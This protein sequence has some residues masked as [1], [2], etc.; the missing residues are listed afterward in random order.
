MITIALQSIIAFAFAIS[1]IP[2]SSIS[3]ASGRVDIDT[4][5][6]V[7][8]RDDFHKSIEMLNAITEIDIDGS[9]FEIKPSL[10][11]RFYDFYLDT[12]SHTLLKSQKYFRFRKR[13]I[14]GFLNKQLLQLK[15]PTIVGNGQAALSEEKT[16]I[17]IRQNIENYNQI[18]EILLDQSNRSGSLS[19]TLSNSVSLQNISPLVSF[20]QNRDRFYLRDENGFTFFT[21]TFDELSVVNNLSV[22]HFYFIELELSEKLFERLSDNALE[23]N[24]SQLRSLQQT[25]F[26]KFNPMEISKLEVVVNELKLK[27]HT[28]NNSIAGVLLSLLLFIITVSI[29]LRKPFKNE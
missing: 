28:V 13:Y 25:L 7:E 4:R 23:A 1:L 18:T 24:L 15:Y 22:E 2:F 12:P 5:L 27:P 8:K 14:N 19:S 21:V 10:A 11:E 6:L 16:E 9:R 3:E 20:T 26:P 29:L 17:D